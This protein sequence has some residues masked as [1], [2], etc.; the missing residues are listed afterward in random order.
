MLGV[1]GASLTRKRSD[2]APLASKSTLH[3]LEHAA[4][5]GADPYCKITHDPAAIERM[6]TTLMIEAHER[7]DAE[8]PRQLII[9]L[10][11]THDP[12]HSAQEG[13]HVNAFYNC[14]CYLSLCIFAGRHLLSAK[15]RSA[16]RNAADGAEDEIARIFGQIRDGW[17]DVRIILRADLM[18]WCE[19]NDVDFLFGLAKN[20]RLVT[21]IKRQLGRARLDSCHPGRAAAV[22][23]P[24]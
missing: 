15:H 1:L 20:T 19:A 18:S 22:A 12:I 10:D 7:L 3:Q 24:S 2:C 9:D 4:K 23:A 16:N 11:A 14:D 6:F 17:P 5:V 8:P 13:R 21:A